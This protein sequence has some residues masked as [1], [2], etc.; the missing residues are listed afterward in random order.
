M[1]HARAVDIKRGINEQFKEIYP[2]INITLSKIR[3]YG[4]VLVHISSN[5]KSYSIKREM[6]KIAIAVSSSLD[7]IVCCLTMQKFV[8]LVLT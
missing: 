2:H 5:Y 1:A 3:R 4:Y 8:R 7:G 6:T